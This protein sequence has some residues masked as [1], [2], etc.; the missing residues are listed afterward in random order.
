MVLPLYRVRSSLLAT[1]N[2]LF[3]SRSVSGASDERQSQ[4]VMKNLGY[5]HS[6]STCHAHLNHYISGIDYFRHANPSGSKIIR[7]TN[8]IREIWIKKLKLGSH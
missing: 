2:R 3:F 1:L 7:R 6:T 8:K 5:L 4:M